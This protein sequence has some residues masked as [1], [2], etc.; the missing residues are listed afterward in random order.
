MLALTV[1]P[2]SSMAFDHLMLAKK[3]ARESDMA[4]GQNATG[5]AVAWKQDQRRRGATRARGRGDR[6]P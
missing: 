3:Q 4:F 1:C 6:H 5:R 2:Q